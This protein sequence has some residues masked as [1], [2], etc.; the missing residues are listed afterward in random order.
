[1]LGGFDEMFDGD[2]L[3]AAQACPLPVLFGFVVFSL[4]KTDDFH[5]G[6]LWNG[7]RIII[8]SLKGQ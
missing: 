5:K 1:V 7:D 8:V 2:L 6:L 4:V 3:F